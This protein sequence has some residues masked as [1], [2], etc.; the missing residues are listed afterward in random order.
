MKV[1]C[2]ISDLLQALQLVSRAIS[3]QQALPILENVLIEAEGKRCT[4]S[5]T[6][7][8]LSIITSFEAEIENEG[9]I[10][11]S[12]RAI[13]NYAQYNTDDEVLLETIEGTQL[14]CISKQSKTLIAGE[15]ASEYPT[16]AP[17]EKKKSFT[18]EGQPLLEALHLVTFASAGSTIRPVLSGVYIRGEKGNLIL[19]ATDSYR[20]S[21]YKL[22]VK[23][24]AEISCIVPAKVLEELRSILSS[25]KSKRSGE[26]EEEKPVSGEVAVTLSGQQIE[27]QVGQTR[28]LSRLIEGKFPDYQQIIPQGA[29]TKSK[30]QTREFL[31]LTKRMHYFAKET[32]NNLTFS[33]TKKGA[34]VS[35]P[36]TQLGKD[37][38]T[39]NTDTEGE[40]NKIA[41]SSSYLLDFLGHIEGSEIG[42]EITDSMHPAVFR[43]P[44]KSEF[45]H[46]I[47]PLRLQ[48]E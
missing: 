40:S 22:K 27:L 9:S 14:Q 35:T 19:A 5:A 1:S 3:T 26:D 39:I 23:G 44:G 24:S 30:L 6:D 7:L 36:Q 2:C 48:E 13:L 18:L 47:M 43:V 20:L 29:K 16:I 32:N 4:V 17:V 8:E 12:A 25:R 46:L 10:T 15:A 11:V 42:M 21:E 38:A 33:F 45:L 31:T 28:L 34:R 37:E 41:L